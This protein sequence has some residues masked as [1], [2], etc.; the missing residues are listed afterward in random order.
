MVEPKIMVLGHSY[1]WRM[2]EY[3]KFTMDKN[4]NMRF[5]LS[6]INSDVLFKGTGGRTMG[7]LIEYD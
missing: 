6:D 4:V 1:I 2:E 5:N 7:A 3:I